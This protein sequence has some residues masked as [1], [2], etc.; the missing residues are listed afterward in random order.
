MTGFL[1]RKQE[2]L[3]VP[4]EKQLAGQLSVSQPERLEEKLTLLTRAMRTCFYCS[5]HRASGIFVEALAV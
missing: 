1:I 5:S 2:L 3:G 4:E